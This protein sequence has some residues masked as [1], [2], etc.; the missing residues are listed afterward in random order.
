MF[1]D[2]VELKDIGKMDAEYRDL[3][4]RVLT[5]QADCE[6]GGP[7][8]YVERMLPAAP[9]KLDQL[10]V[11]RTAAEEIDHFRKVARVAGDMG[12]DVSFVLSQPNEK[13]FVESFRGLIKTWEDHAVFGFLI[14]RVGRYQLEEFYDCSYQPLQRILPDIVT[15]ELGHIDYGYNKTRELLMKGDEQKERVQKAVDY[16]YVK[17]LDM[18]GRSGSQRAERYR[19]W[20]LKRRTNEQARK[21]YIDEVNPI[22]LSMGLKIPDPLIGRRYI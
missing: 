5:I 17:A 11:A 10:I 3:L 19:Y 2:K 20:G 4:G 22:L 18:F 14:D 1:T 21:D 7:H 15:E 6:I 9:S 8:L 12:V 16:W 13:R